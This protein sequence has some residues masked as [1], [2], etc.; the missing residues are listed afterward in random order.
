MIIYVT[1]CDS[2]VTTIERD[3]SK[4]EN[5]DWS[6]NPT[7][8]DIRVPPARD[9]NKLDVMKDASKISWGAPVIST[10]NPRR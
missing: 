8:L 6:S 3:D 1:T 5:G 9:M 7:K 10:E 4:C 2:I